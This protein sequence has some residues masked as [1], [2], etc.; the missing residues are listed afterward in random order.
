MIDIF[1]KKSE[2][3]LVDFDSIRLSIASPE[4]INEWSWGEV[5]KP[6]T[7]NYRTFKPEKD[8]LFCER[9]F[10]PVK[11]WECNC[12]KYKRMKSRGI[13][14]DR[15][16][17]E[18]TQSK[19]RR[20]RMGHI[21]LASM[22]THIWFYKG[23]PSYIGCLLDLTVTDLGRVIY[24]DDFVVTN[25]GSTPLQEKKLLSEEEYR[26]YKEKYGDSFEAK[27]GGEA[28]YDLLAKLDLDKLSVELREIGRASCRERV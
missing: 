9:T 12:G 6:E 11:D 13:V 28:I 19:V 24:F 8:G 14:C 2:E 17:V 1:R 22:V 4:L 5:K 7:I 16:G 15:C 23:L 18:V 21:E 10:G 26:E 3:P 27:M 25:A 20:E